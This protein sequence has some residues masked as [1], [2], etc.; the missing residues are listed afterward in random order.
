MIQ[1]L[2]LS[3]LGELLH[4]AEREEQRKERDELE[5]RLFPLWLAN[6]ALSKMNGG[7]VMDYDEFIARSLDTGQ[8][9]RREER[10][11]KRTAEEIMKDFAPLVAADRKKGG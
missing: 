2:P 10:A 3:F 9:D 8:A 11:P 6:Y 5:K 1:S 4:H 7:E